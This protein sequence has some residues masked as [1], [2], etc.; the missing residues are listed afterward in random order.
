MRYKRLATLLLT[1]LAVTAPLGCLAEEAEEAEESEPGQILVVYPEEMDRKFFPDNLSALAEILLSL[2]YT[3]DYVEAEKAKG[4][5]GQYEN[6]IWFSASDSDRMDT[7]LLSG[8]SGHLLVLGRGG[9]LEEFG[10]TLLSGAEDE[11]S[12]VAEYTF[13]DDYPFRD[14]VRLLQPGVIGDAAYRAGALE[15]AD[16]SLSLA[17]ALNNVRYIP[18][19]DYT[20]PFAKAVLTQEIAQWLWPYE[21]RM[22]TYTE[23]V[24]LDNLYPFSDLYRLREAVDYMVDKKMNFVLSVMPIYI[25]Q[26]YPAM[27]EFCEVL[28]FAQSS[29]GGV[30][31]HAPIVQNG[32][33]AEELAV[34]LT[35]AFQNYLSQDVYLLGMEI[36]SEWLFRDDLLPII[37]RT[38]TLFLS[39][40]DAFANHSVKEL[41][42][43]NYLNLGSQQITPAIQ[44][45]ETGVSHLTRCSTAVYLDM[46]ETEERQI[47]AVIDAARGAPIPMQSLWEMEEAFFVNDGY[48]LTWDR[49]TL[50]VNDEQRFNV[51]EPREPKTGFNYRRNVYYRFVTDLA[52]QNYFLI[53]ISAIVLVMFLL[54]AFRSRRQMHRRFLKKIRKPKEENHVGG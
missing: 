28:R 9:G 33:D 38:Q 43:K 47:Y 31:L 7:T 42:L 32:V 23:Y 22:H 44:L 12:A 52:K 36:P 17:S 29:G 6:V 53:G 25:H 54:L 51:Y 13:I 49:D 30:I 16:K 2:R 37:G 8:F 45:D 50:T 46:G 21:S 41:G 26:D 5:I 1:L 39:E 35:T 18:L 19:M 4:Q 11:Y 20:L 24:V 14:S 10:I 34:Q 40:T 48:Y 27:Q 15:T 3:A